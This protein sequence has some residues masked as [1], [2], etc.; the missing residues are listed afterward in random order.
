MPVVAKVN[1]VGE[2]GDTSYRPSVLNVAI[3]RNSETNTNGTI[4]AAEGWEHTWN[5]LN[6]S[7]RYQYTVRVTD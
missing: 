6:P 7:W 3:L 5:N 1:W 4:T 2:N